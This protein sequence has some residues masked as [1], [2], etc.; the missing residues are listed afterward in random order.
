VPAGRRVAGAGAALLVVGATIIG[1]EILLARGGTPPPDAPPAPSDGAAGPPGAATDTVVW[2]GD[3]TAAGVGASTQATTVA[4]QV[5]TRTGRSVRLTVLAVSG[6]RVAGVLHEQLPKVAAVQ[7]TIVFVSVGANDAVH[8]TSTSAFR[9]DYRRLLSRL[10]GSVRRVVLLG[11]PDMGAP[12]RLAQPLRALTGWRGRAMDREVEA[13]ARA[14]QLVY[15]DIAGT[16]GPAFRRDPGHS[17]ARDHYHPS[18]AGYAL[19][20]DAVARA[21][22]LGSG[23]HK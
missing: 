15:V 21:L 16:T 18:D 14:R 11:V 17:F 10:P 2:L 22:A 4:E 19:W 6:A 13:L 7:P 8:L 12:P 9:R 5:A 3:S 1:A 23:D 20:A